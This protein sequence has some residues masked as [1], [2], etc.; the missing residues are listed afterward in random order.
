MFLHIGGDDY[1]FKDDIVAILDVKT[2]NSSKDTSR[3]IEKMI[4]DGLLKNNKID[5]AKTYIIT[6]R[7]GRRRGSKKQYY[8][9]MSNIS[10]STLLYR[11]NRRK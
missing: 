8:L 11:N 2:V 3:L 10:S 1:V 6:C 7:K 9:Y 5:D 4:R